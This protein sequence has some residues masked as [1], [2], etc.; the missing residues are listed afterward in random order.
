MCRVGRRCFPHSADKLDRAE[1]E[2][3]RAQLVHE[4]RC[5]HAAMRP[6]AQAW[7]DESEAELT[8]ARTRLH[9]RQIEMA[10]TAR[11]AYNMLLEAQAYEACGQDDRAAALRRTV[12]RGMA[13]RRAADVAENPAAAEGW[14]PPQVRGGGERCSACGQ[15]AAAAHRCPDAILEAQR[16]ALSEMSG[17]VPPSQPTATGE[18]AAAANQLGDSFYRDIPLTGRDADAI[19]ALCTDDLYGPPAPGLPEVPR[20]GDGSIDVDSAEF[21]QHRDVALG[22]AQAV[23]IEDE[24][25]DGIP[26]PIVVAQ[27]AMEPFAV[28]AKREAA[29]L[30][31]DELA[32]VD[33]RDLFDEAECA[34]LADPDRAQ[35]GASSTGICWRTAGDA[36]WREVGSGALVGPLDL[37]AVTAADAPQLARRAIASQS[38]AAWAAH[39]ERTPSPV[40]LHTQAAV[41]DMFVAPNPDPPQTLDARRAR[42]V[43]RAQYAITQRRLAEMGISEVSVSRGFW[44]PLTESTP[45]WVPDEKGARGTAEVPLNAAAS[46]TVRPEVASYF[47]RREWDDEQYVS[48][49]LHGTV[50]ASRILSLPRTG[51]GCLAEEEVVVIGGR[52]QWEVERV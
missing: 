38:M 34:A 22:R 20:R 7:L 30:L 26:V 31:G 8:K 12:T 43:V 27:G 2:V 4:S 1:A 32:D 10:S 49:R 40:A 50:P 45:D 17:G 24:F 3:R 23:C 41:R 21:A 15:F 36:D 29:A 39:T 52:G 16:R 48:V 28:P 47:A 9:T 51:M 35:W 11:G 19:V 14:Q 18:G 37:T 5:A 42:A 25:I 33:D 44:Y 46:F 13:R 6:V